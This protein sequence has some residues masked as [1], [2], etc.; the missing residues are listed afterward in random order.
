MHH[1]PDARPAAVVAD[2]RASPR[3]LARLAPPGPRDLLQASAAARAAPGAPRR[4]TAHFGVGG[5]AVAACA[6]A[7]PAPHAL[8]AFA[9]AAAAGWEGVRRGLRSGGGQEW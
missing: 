9:D 4:R 7:T 1:L 5:R 2:L 8:I 3:A 6:V